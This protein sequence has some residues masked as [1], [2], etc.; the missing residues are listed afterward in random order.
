MQVILFI[1]VVV[2][3]AEVAVGDDFG[4]GFSGLPKSTGCFIQLFLAA[5]K[6]WRGFLLCELSLLLRAESFRGISSTSSLARFRRIGLLASGVW[7]GGKV[8]WTE[9]ACFGKDVDLDRC[10]E[11]LALS[12]LELCDASSEEASCASPGR[13]SSMSIRTRTGDLFFWAPL[14]RHILGLFCPEEDDVSQLVVA[15][16]RGVDIA[17]RRFCSALRRNLPISF[18][19]SCDISCDTPSSGVFLAMSAIFC[20]F[21][22]HVASL[23]ERSKWTFR[24]LG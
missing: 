21:S 4:L 14:L 20:N 13:S 22:K 6:G 19:T 17:L 15:S 1:P 11:S 18:F 3:P 5:P 23:H 7:L 2:L 9:Q 12:D 24:I 16:D 8:L 10:G